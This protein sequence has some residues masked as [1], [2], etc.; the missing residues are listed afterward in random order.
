MLKEERLTGRKIAMDNRSI[1][2]ESEFRS[3]PVFNCELDESPYFTEIYHNNKNKKLRDHL[4]LYLHGSRKFTNKTE[5]NRRLSIMSGNMLN[6]VNLSE[7]D[8]FLTGSS[9]V[10]CVVTNPLEEHFVDCGDPFGKYIENYYPSYISMCSHMD[11]FEYYKKKVIESIMC[12]DE[13][14][15]LGDH[16]IYDEFV[17]NA[18]SFVD[19][20]SELQ[21]NIADL[22]N[23]YH[24]LLD[25]EKKLSDM[26][27]A[28][29][30]STMEE[31]TEKVHAIV[32]KI[33]TNL[34]SDRQHFVYLY[35]QQIKYGFKWVLKGPGAKRP[36]DF[37]RITKHAHS[38][39]HSFHLN[40][41]RFWWDG[42]KVRGLSSA[43][44][45]ALTGVNQWYRWFSNNKDPMNI[46]LKNMQRGYTTLLNIEEIR[47]LKEYINEMDAYKCLAGKFII[48]KIHKNH[49]IFNYGIGIR[50]QFPE[51]LVIFN[52]SIDN[53]QY[54]P[55]MDYTVRRIGC[56]L[57]LHSCG[58]IKTPKAYAFSSIINSLLD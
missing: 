52:R 34:P 7:H 46:V 27:I 53:A 26:D 48:G 28:V 55:N 6:N 19:E 8:A 58:K 50:Y 1:M 15:D 45:A 11:V 37:F 31:Y 38:L 25:M 3:L 29:I 13:K 20:H 12:F 43:V 4:P 35:K 14:H 57:K 47:V 9:L 21:I 33:R 41:V 10:P 2:D 49:A 44:C 17:S 36:I 5:F 24:A 30:A 16:L 54:W 56:S 32:E 39:L 51:Q 42:V 23:S 40:I 22:N 18:N